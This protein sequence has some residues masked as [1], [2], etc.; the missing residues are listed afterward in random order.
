VERSGRYHFG[1]PLMSDLKPI[2]DFKLSGTIYPPADPG[3]FVSRLSPQMEFK[4][5]EKGVVRFS[6]EQQ[7]VHP[8]AR[9]D[10]EYRKPGEPQPYLN[11]FV[12]SEGVFGP[13]EQYF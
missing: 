3:S 5:D 8:P 2:W 13:E 9:L 10:I 6:S 4:A 7:H 1:L 11:R 12:T